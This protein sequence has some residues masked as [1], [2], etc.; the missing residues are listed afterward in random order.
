MN[1]E[2]FDE[3]TEQSQAKA[4]IA[5]KYFDAWAKVVSRTGPRL[6]RSELKS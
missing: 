2:F 3:S 1:R 4:A 6:T 5:S